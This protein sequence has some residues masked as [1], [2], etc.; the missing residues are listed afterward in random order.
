[1]PSYRVLLEKS[2]PDIENFIES[3]LGKKTIFMTFL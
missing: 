1:M 3:T 2:K